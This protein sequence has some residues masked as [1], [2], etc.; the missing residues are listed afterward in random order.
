MV[1]QLM[2]LGTKISVPKKGFLTKV[3]QVPKHF[4]LI[5]SGFIRCYNVNEDGKEFIRTIFLPNTPTGSLSGLVNN[6]PSTLNYQA[7]T[8]CVLYKVNFNDFKKL[9]DSDL[10]AAKFYYQVLEKL[11]LGMEER[12]F[13]LSSLNATE[14]Y[15][16]LKKD[17]PDIETLMPQYQIASYLN[18][19]AVQLSRLK[20]DL[21]E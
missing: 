18:V 12:V 19:S 15:L 7:L 20:K 1:D 8:D 3:G 16:K 6:K 5:R 4:Y 13:E 9:V 21:Q 11:F 10:T 2:H 17:I 14:K